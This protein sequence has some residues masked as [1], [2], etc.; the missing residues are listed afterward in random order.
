MSWRSPAY[1]YPP[2]NSTLTSTY[3]EHDNIVRAGINYKF[4]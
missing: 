4:W 3:S 2:F 1:A